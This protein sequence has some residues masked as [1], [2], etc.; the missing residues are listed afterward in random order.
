MPKLFT[1]GYGGRTPN[2]LIALLKA[3]GVDYV[4]DIR[5][6]QSRA[7][8]RAFWAGTEMEVTLANKGVH[9]IQYRHA[10][11]LAN[12]YDDLDEY[13][14][15]LNGKEGQ[16]GIRN[17]AE[18]IMKGYDYF[19]KGKDVSYCLLCYEKKPYWEY[20]PMAIQVGSEKCHR[21]YVAD[22]LVG[23]LGEGWEVKHL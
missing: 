5:R 12:H 15:W 4:I 11:N 8:I 13:R 22:A 20:P 14:Q 3:H 1:V 21:V 17:E 6:E 7:F 9:G 19:H 2:E 10:Y 23:L 18:W 16:G